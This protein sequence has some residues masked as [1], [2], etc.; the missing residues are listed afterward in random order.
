MIK[1]LNMRPKSHFKWLQTICN[2]EDSTFIFRSQ[3]S[4]QR[5]VNHRLSLL[6]WST[7]G[8]YGTTAKWATITNSQKSKHQ[9]LFSARYRYLC[10]HQLTIRYCSLPDTTSPLLKPSPYNP[11]QHDPS[12]HAWVFQVFTFIMVSWLKIYMHFSHPPYMALQ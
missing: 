7:S 10:P 3:N 4:F 9:F 1:Q 2:D 8:K 5:L 12:I 11:F 6:L